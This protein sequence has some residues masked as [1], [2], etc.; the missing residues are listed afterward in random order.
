VPKLEPALALLPREGAPRLLVGGGANMMGAARPLTWIEDVAPLR[1]AGKEIARCGAGPIVIGA[2]AMTMRLRQEIAPDGA[3]DGTTTLRRLM[4]RKSAA[5]RDAIQAAC[6]ILAAAMTAIGDAKRS[7]AG[8]TATVLAGERAANARGVQDVRTLFSVNGGRTLQPFETLI[9]RVAEPL[10]IYVAIRC[11]NYWTEGFAR[12]AERPGPA[13][14]TAA[15]AL[16]QAIA[17]VTAGV[18]LDFVAETMADAVR[19]FQCHPVTRGSAVSAIGLTLNEE[20]TG[21]DERFEPGGVYSLRAGVSDGAREHAIIS[22]MIEVADGGNA[23]LW[24]A[25]EAR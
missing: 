20:T 8:V 9:E 10:Q 13:A 5:E 17:A 7:G 18:R 2:D 1:D 4:R 19:P 22:A 11:H 21:E 23:I 15:D 16:R 3:R 24:S 12:F 14:T 25:G 6:A